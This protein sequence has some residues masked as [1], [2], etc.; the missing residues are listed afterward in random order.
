ML[1]EAK[2]PAAT[3][4]DAR[5]G[6]FVVSHGV[7]RANVLR[8]DDPSNAQL[9]QLVGV[10]EAP[11]NAWAR[12]SGPVEASDVE[13]IARGFTDAYDPLEVEIRTSMAVQVPTV[14]GVLKRLP[15]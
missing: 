13:W 2:L 9:A 5:F 1:H 10:R 14:V 12:L 7:K 11:V 8:T 6:D 15:K 4:G 3:I